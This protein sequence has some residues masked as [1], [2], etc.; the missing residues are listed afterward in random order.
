M[1]II[2]I[3]AINSFNKTD[4]RRVQFKANPVKPKNAVKVLSL[5]T[6]GCGTIITALQTGEQRMEETK[7]LYEQC[8][9]YL[10]EGYTL[11]RAV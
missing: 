10:A 9:P 6:A 4:S 11:G 2:S 8:K 1:K 7:K 5:L 3:N